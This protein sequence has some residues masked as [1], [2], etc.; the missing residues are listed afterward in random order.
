LRFPRHV[1]LNALFL[2]PAGSGGPETYL[3]GLA[4]ALRDAHPEAR[5]TVAT[6][7]SGAE[8]LRADGWG[9][10]AAIRA[11]PC[12]EGQRGRRQLAEQVLLPLLARHV[13][14]D[15]VHS[16]ASVAPIRVVGPAH[17]I[18]LH[19]VTFFRMRTFGAV[20]TFGMRQVVSRAARHAD[21]LIAVTAA[22]RDEIVAELGLPPERFSVVH[23]GAMRPD[24]VAPA[25]EADVR[26]RYGLDG[27]DVVLCV[28][29]KRPHKNQE[30]LVR[31]APLL[32]D[33]AVVVLAGHP[34]PY[35]AELRALAAELGVQERVRFADY[36]PDAD[37]EALWRIAGVA[38]F[39]TRAEGFGMPVLDALAR[40][41]PVVCSDLPVLREV[42]G[43]HARTFSP[44]DPG[45][46]A[47]AIGEALRDPDA[48]ADGPGWA[49]RF[50]WA[51]AAA[52]TWG[53]YERCTSG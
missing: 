45:G 35:D 26:S 38:A 28:A 50:T 19:D 11:L 47:A 41:V 20:T 23:H 7:R 39:P 48:G 29:S 53:A 49:A 13:R 37:L 6:T 32:G 34:E 8:A 43:G 21:A 14:A 1:L 4:P 36:V 17:V 2:D 18:T 15:V 46:A 52:G 12:E 3:R 16:L 9:E 42:S 5:L 22:A 31:A 44:D 33:D 40:G 27:R 25:P 24:P 10:W 30:L 51:A